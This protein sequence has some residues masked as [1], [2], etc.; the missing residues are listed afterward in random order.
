RLPELRRLVAQAAAECGLHPVSTM[1]EARSMLTLLADVESVYARLRPEV[2]TGPVDAWLVATGDRAYRRT[3]AAK[4]GWL[5]R[6]AGRKAA[7][8]LWMSGRPGKREL[9]QALADVVDVGR[10]WRAV[11]VDGRAPRG[12]SV[13][14]QAL[15]VLE[16]T[17]RDVAAVPVMSAETPLDQLHWQADALA[18]D[19]HGLDRAVRRNQLQLELRQWRADRLLDELTAR[20]AGADLAVAAFDHAWLTSVLDHIRANDP[21]LRGFDGDVL[22]AAAEEFRTAD[23]EHVRQTPARVRRAAAAH[24]VA[25]LD[26]FPE[27]QDLVRREA[28]KKSRHLPIRHLFEKAPH[29][30][31]A[32]KPCW[33]MSPLLVSQVLPAQRLFDVVIFDEASQVLPVDGITA[34]MRGRQLVVAGDE[35]QLPPTSFFDKVDSEVEPLDAAEEDAEAY[36]D[37]VESLLQAFS[38]VLPLPQVTHLAWHYRSRDERLIAF[39]NAHIYAPHGN[40]LVTFPGGAAGPTLRHVLVPPAPSRSGSSARS[41]TATES[42]SA[43]VDKVVE[44]ILDHYETR[45]DESLGVITMGI[46]HADRIDLALRRALATRSH[47]HRFFAERGNEPFFVKNIERVQGDE[48]DAI[49]LSV[50]YAPGPDGRMLYRFGPLNQQGGHR[51]LNVAVTR[52]KRRMTVVSSFSSHDLDP[53][54]LRADGARMLR[55]YLQ[56]A[57]SIGAAAGIT[58]GVPANPFEAD[59]LEKLTAAGIPLIPQYGVGGHRIDFAARHPE[60]PNR[61]VLAIEADGSAYHASPTA[62]DRDRLRQ[63]H[64]ERLGWR[65]HRI[66]STDWFHRRDAEIARAVSAYQDAVAGVPDEEPDVVGRAVVPPARVGEAPELA[67]GL[68]I[69]DYPFEKL[70]DLM[71]WI[72][73]D[74]RL[75]TSEDVLSEAM[76]RLG[77]ARRGPR[78]V[79]TL[80]RAIQTARG[81]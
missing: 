61:M 66:W 57:E 81:A 30:L 28:A 12:S 20:Q 80:T 31:P 6:R 74:G 62:R 9:H 23:A 2:F 10:R 11:S 44:L 4:A 36:T 78:I 59:V 49:I 7:A 68:P 79:D 17:A 73:S 60:D 13:T 33:A 24:M 71:R 63:E 48:R 29:A 70:V 76:A 58:G 27:E 64:L 72:E 38:S 42:A 1:D 75:R 47:L 53:A 21:R 45:P 69:A 54:K 22:H 46:K 15:V 50:G 19:S 34:V 18:A 40:E 55:S 41:E 51:R 26:K 32:I 67:I 39:S 16:E 77:F 5:E 25:V 52:A 43:E 35:H 65:F 56:Y 37:D 8:A 3:R 14:Q